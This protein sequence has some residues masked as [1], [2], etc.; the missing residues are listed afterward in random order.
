MKQKSPGVSLGEPGTPGFSLSP[1]YRV[2]EVR[3]VSPSSVADRFSFKVLLGCP[4]CCPPCWLVGRGT[5]DAAADSG[6]RSGTQP[7]QQTPYFRRRFCIVTR[8]RRG[9][10]RTEHD[11]PAAE[12]DYTVGMYYSC[13]AFVR[14]ERHGK[15]E[16]T[17]YC[18]LHAVVLSPNVVVVTPLGGHGKESRPWKVIEGTGRWTDG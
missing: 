10:C 13:T 14:C 11:C 8:P 15:I 3:I 5:T 2:L 12:C 16:K 4:N 1:A 17:A 9:G 6:I 7:H 18:W